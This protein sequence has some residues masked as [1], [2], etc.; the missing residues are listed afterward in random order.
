MRLFPLLLLSACSIANSQDFNPAEEYVA[1]NVCPFECCTY[2]EGWRP[3]QEVSLYE[4]KDTS[5]EVIALLDADSNV[6]VVTGDWHVIPQ[7][8]TILKTNPSYPSYRPGDQYWLLNYIGEGEYHAWKDGELTYFGA[9]FSPWSETPREDW[10][11]LEGDYQYT[12]W[13]KVQTEAVVGWSNTPE[14][15]SQGDRCG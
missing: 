15:F 3:L 7:K 8:V 1:T 6:Q 2:E 9:Y 5:S 11:E 4:A 10:F 14:F 12:W 13:L